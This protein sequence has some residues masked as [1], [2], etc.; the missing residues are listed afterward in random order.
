MKMDAIV[1]AGGI[2]QPGEP[3]YEYT[4]GK[5]KAMLDINSKPM[6]QWVLDALCEATTVDHVVIVG[7][8]EDS[9]IECSKLAGHLPNQ[10]TMLG[11]IKA[12]LQKV[13]EIN[14][15]VQHVLIVSSD[16]PAI[17]GEMVDHVINT[18]MQTDEDA[19]Y[20]VISRQTME[21]RYPGSNRTY[22]RF[23]DIELCGGDMNVIRASLSTNDAFWEK[24]IA[25]RKSPLKQAGLLGFD[26]LLLVLFHAVTLD[27]AVKRVTKRIGLTGRA[28][29]CPYAEV[30]MDVDKPN[31][32]EMVR[33][34]M[35]RQKPA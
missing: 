20:N 23:K 8:P 16:I 1:T 15:D 22:T 19:Y 17:T 33:A 14:P 26:T 25:A 7:L 4:L 27:G 24:V 2:P 30:G 31:Q 13:R 29:I 5:S 32:L 28:L 21:A 6:I 3:L 10:E 11:N 9:G 35:A 34:D 12:G 18:A